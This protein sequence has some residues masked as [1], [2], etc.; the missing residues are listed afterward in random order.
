MILFVTQGLWVSIV[1]ICFLVCNLGLFEVLEW[2]PQSVVLF[3]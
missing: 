2:E 1:Q 3:G